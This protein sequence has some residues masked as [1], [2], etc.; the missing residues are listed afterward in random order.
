MTLRETRPSRPRPDSG[1]DSVHLDTKRHSDWSGHT[2]G[3][4]TRPF[5]SE[6]SYL[7]RKKRKKGSINREIVYVPTKRWGRAAPV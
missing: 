1:C 6:H 7:K 3:T 5:G 4:T 2:C